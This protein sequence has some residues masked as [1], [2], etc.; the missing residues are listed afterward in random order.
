M[1]IKA[2][3]NSGIIES[4]VLGM[5]TDTECQEVELL[6]KQYPEISAEIAE[7]QKSMETYLSET[8]VTPRPGLQD[9]IWEKLES[10][11]AAAPIIETP[12]KSTSAKIRLLAIQ[13]YLAAAVLLL[14]L[15]SVI[16]NI[17]LSRQLGKTQDQ[18]SELNASNLRIASQLETQKVAFNELENQFAFM[19]SPNTRTVQLAGLPN[20]PDASAIVY[21]NTINH[22]VFISGASL[23]ALTSEKQYQLWAIVDGAPVSAGLLS[24]DTDSALQKMASFEKAQAFAITVEPKGGSIHPTLEAMVVLGPV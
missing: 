2:Y 10:K 13:P 12:I 14:L 7:V 22:E 20:H 9:A 8:T 6:A 18:L 1:D 23:P 5:L 17:Y 11:S 21:W 3:I 24:A 16:T 19:I 4:Y 15:T